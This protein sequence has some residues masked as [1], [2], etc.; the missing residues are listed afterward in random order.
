MGSFCNFID[1]L[2]KLLHYITLFSIKLALFPFTF[3]KM[4][5]DAPTPYK[6]MDICLLF[7][8]DQHWI[9]GGGG[10]YGF[11]QKMFVQQMVQTCMFVL[12]T[13]VKKICP[14]GKKFRFGNEKNTV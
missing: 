4:S 10:G 2:C 3:F 13:Y 5:A 6:G 9:P 8:A 7:R 1:F 14:E 11:F 12:T